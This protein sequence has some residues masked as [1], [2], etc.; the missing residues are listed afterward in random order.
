MRCVSLIFR[1]VLALK[2]FY[3]HVF[4]PYGEEGKKLPR[5]SGTVPPRK[6]LGVT[7]PGRGK[8]DV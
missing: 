5:I 1:A 4:P 7:W 6:E 3:N 2:Y 8:S